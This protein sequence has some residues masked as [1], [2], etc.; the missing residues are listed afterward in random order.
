MVRVA[1]LADKRSWLPS[2][3]NI[4]LIRTDYRKQ[5][6]ER[7]TREA[8]LYSHLSQTVFM[9]RALNIGHEHEYA[10]IQI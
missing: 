10:Y 4:T 7:I 9:A 5:N 3:L 1:P 2:R 8:L 6:D